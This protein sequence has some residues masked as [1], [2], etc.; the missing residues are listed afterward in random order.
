MR[1]NKNLFFT[2]LVIFTTS[3]TFKG[4]STNM[5]LCE[6]MFFLTND[7]NKRFPEQGNYFD[8]I[9]SSYVF[10]YYYDDLNNNNFHYFL[11]YKDDTIIDEW[12]TYETDGKNVHV[13]LNNGN[14]LDFVYSYYNSPTIDYILLGKITHNENSYHL[15]YNALY[16]YSTKG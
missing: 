6:N 4:Y 10:M 3:C 2:S 11:E 1:L 12:G 7:F 8:F 15:V 14:K 13:F 16:L 9:K 5:Y